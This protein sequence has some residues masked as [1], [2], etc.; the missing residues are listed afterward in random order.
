MKLDLTK[1][2]I[3]IIIGSL[4]EMPHKYVHELITKIISQTQENRS[5]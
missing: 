4:Q 1:E 3:N 5:E 2:D